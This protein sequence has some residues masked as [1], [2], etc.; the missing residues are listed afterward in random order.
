LSFKAP[1]SDATKRSS[2]LAAKPT[3][4]MTTMDKA[5]L[6]LMKKGGLVLDEAS[7]QAADLQRYRTLYSKPLTPEFIGAVSALVEKNVG[8]K[9]KPAE[10]GILAA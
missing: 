8:G 10:A 2:R 7:P 4:G 5:Q 3:A 6:V 1:Q 9:I